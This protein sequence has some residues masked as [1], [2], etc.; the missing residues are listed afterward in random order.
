MNFT[1]RD[2][3]KRWCRRSFDAFTHGID[4]QQFTRILSTAA[5]GAGKTIC[6]SAFMW[7]VIEKLGRRALFLADTD[8]LVFQAAEKIH[9][10]AGF[11]PGIEKASARAGHKPRAVVGSI[12]TISQPDRLATWPAD[13]FGLVIADEAHLSM[14]E[15]WQRTLKHFNGGGAWILGVTATP[16]RGDGQD[17]FD[18]YEHLGD[19][20]GLFELID[21]GFLAPIT[22]E[23]VPVSIDCTGARVGDYADDGNDMEESI[24]PYWDAIIAEWQQRARTR[25]TLWF[26]PGIR[27]SK[28]FTARLQAAGVAA[29]HID[30]KSPDRRAILAEFDRGDFQCLNCSDLLIKG[31]DQ[32][33]IGCVVVLRPTKSRVY[34]QQMIGRGTRTA[35]GKTDCLVLDFLWEF[36]ERMKPS[37]PADLVTRDPEQ[38]QR[39]ADA[40]KDGKPT[41]LTEAAR[42][43]ERATEA[44]LIDRLK[45]L[46]AK[47]RGMR[48]DA[49]EL[50]ALLQQPD[51]VQFTPT[52]HWQKEKP[53]ARQKEVLKKFGVKVSGLR[54]RGE[55]SRLL[56]VI[57][58]RK[59]AGMASPKQV[60]ALRINGVETAHQ[61]SFEAAGEQ[62]DR[63]LATR[64]RSQWARRVAEPV[65]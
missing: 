22:V 42:D 38:W 31:Y 2:Y 55:A 52:A 3:Q 35:P 17:L 24:E 21:R 7:M 57:F 46:A 9:A 10:A 20:I 37:G 29:K 39:I 59:E 58:E 45:Q 44:E 47:H 23:T 62:L 25:K 26:H 5:T 49:R 4:G 15:S 43:T 54:T 28:R 6:A 50:G 63:V 56:D 16:E 41:D 48:F 40:L 53:T 19:E 60:A 13:H 61:L 27:A 30:G 8:D 1:L 51:L 32:P 18:F 11:V 36:E 65:S 12:Q 64:P 33:D 34:Y 14:A